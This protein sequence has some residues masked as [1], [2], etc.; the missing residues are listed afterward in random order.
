MFPYALLAVRA[1]MADQL[2]GARVDDPVVPDVE[3]HVAP[4]TR[5]WL[6][7]ALRTAAD[8]SA[9]SRPAKVAH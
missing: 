9:P 4:R 7:G 6:A 8:H 1:S 5:T 3:R 2:V